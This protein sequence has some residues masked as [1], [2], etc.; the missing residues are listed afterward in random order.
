MRKPSAGCKSGRRPTPGNPASRRIHCDSRTTLFSTRSRGP[1]FS[2]RVRT[3]TRSTPLA[4]VISSK[5]FVR[6]THRAT[7]K[8]LAE[9]PLGWAVTPF[10]GHYYIGKKYLL[11]DAFRLN[12][13][14]GLCPYKFLYVW[15]DLVLPD[16]NTDKSLGWMYWF[17]GV[18]AKIAKIGGCA[19]SYLSRVQSRPTRNALVL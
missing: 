17:K 5:T 16:T 7:G 10:E 13:I 1:E 15:L 19:P 12:Y 11:T 8:L 2:G 14:P 3:V 9:G 4:K 6:I 18:P